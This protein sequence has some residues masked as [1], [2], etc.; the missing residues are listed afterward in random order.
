MFMANKVSVNE[1][2]IQRCACATEINK[3]SK[4]LDAGVAGRVTVICGM[5]NYITLSYL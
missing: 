3:Y 4:I 5:L 2:C 1:D